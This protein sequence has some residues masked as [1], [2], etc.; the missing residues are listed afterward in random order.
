ML[1]DVVVAD[2]RKGG[3]GRTGNGGNGGN[4]G[5]GCCSGGSS[6]PQAKHSDVRSILCSNSSGVNSPMELKLGSSMLH[7]VV[8]LFFDATT[9]NTILTLLS[10]TKQ[11]LKAQ[12]FRLRWKV[13]DFACA[14]FRSG[15]QNLKK[16]RYNHSYN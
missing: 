15:S 10:S 14:Q 7:T 4:G 6:L 11:L 9:G 16:I 2:V 3:N 8:S 5:G 1:D 12:R 13:A